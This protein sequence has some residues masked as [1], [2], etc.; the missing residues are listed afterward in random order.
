[1]SYH[2]PEVF[3]GSKFKGLA[4]YEKAISAM[5]KDPAGIKKNWYY[6]RINMVLA[7]WYLT[8]NRTFAAHEIYRKMIA[9][10]PG[11]EE[12]KQRLAK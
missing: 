4:S 5:E 2:M 3:G 7:D 11:M 9:M 1:M 6:V 10:E 12:A 8:R